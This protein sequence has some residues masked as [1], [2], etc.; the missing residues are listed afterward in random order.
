MI[1]VGSIE[2]KRAANALRKVPQAAERAAYRA[3]NTVSNKV[4]TRAVREIGAEINLPQS[5]IREQMSITPATLG[6]PMAIVRARIRDV[7]LARF[8]AKQITAPARRARGDKR[9]GIPAGRKQAGVSVKV[10]RDGGRTRMPGAF[11]LPLRAGKVDG[12]NGMGIFVRYK[13][14]IE[15][16]YGPAPY[17][18]FRRWKDEKAPDV[19][20][21]LLD[22]Y[23]AQLRFELRGT[24]K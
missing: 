13:N 6:K 17:Q 23:R 18:L 19:R 22:A 20:R 5:Y 10:A 21:M 8:A 2:L 14:I 24:R 3:V 4:M 9:R 12:G 11:L 15:H 7:R 16:R 1:V